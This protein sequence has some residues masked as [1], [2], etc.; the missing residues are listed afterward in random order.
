MVRIFF[1]YILMLPVLKF[2]NFLLIMTSK[3]PI[4]LN[5]KTYILDIV[6]PKLGL[7]DVFSS[8][9]STRL[10]SYSSSL[11]LSFKGILYTRCSRHFLNVMG[12]N[13]NPGLVSLIVLSTGTLFIWNDDLNL[14]I[15]L[16]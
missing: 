6:L 9:L 5:S 2:F 8:S 11:M 12:A 14:Q 16:T 7:V 1:V 3:R 10:S 15:R 4:L 13:V